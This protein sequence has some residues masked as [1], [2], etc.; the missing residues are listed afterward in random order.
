VARIKN[1]ILVLLFFLVLLLIAACG[2]IIGE[3]NSQTKEESHKT[4]SFV[5]DIIAFVSSFILEVI[6]V[7]LLSILTK[8]NTDTT[9]G[10][11]KF[12]I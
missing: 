7:S 12:A 10:K 1:N 3:R 9:I 6:S 4:S 5:F 8:R 11:P 2:L